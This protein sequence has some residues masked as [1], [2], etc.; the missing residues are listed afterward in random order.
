MKKQY[1]LDLN[2]IHDDL[3]YELE[4]ISE[5]QRACSCMVEADNP[6]HAAQLI[7][8]KL[9]PFIKKNLR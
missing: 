3:Y 6:K 5:G 4:H 8:K 9:K 7:V 2:V 1:A